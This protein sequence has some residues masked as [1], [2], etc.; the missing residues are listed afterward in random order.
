[1]PGM[2]GALPPL[3]VPFFGGGGHDRA[4]ALRIDAAALAA[5][6]VRPNARLLLLDGLDP[7][8]DAAGRLAWTSL[9]QAEADADLLFLGLREGCPIFAQITSNRSGIDARSRSVWRVLPLLDAQDAGLY[10]AARSLIDWHVRHG[11]CASCGT[12][13]AM[14]KGGWART[15][16]A[17]GAEHFPRVDPVVIMLAEHQGRVL[18][19]RQ[20]GFPPGRYSALAGFL[21]VGE[22]IED[23]VARELHEEAG[24]IV[25][26]VRYV[27]SQPWPFPSSLMIGCVAQAASDVITLD[28][29][30]LEDA[31]W[32][33][34]AGVA[35]ALADDAAAPF[36][37]PP[38]FAIAHHLLVHW[39]A[40]A[41]SPQD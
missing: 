9:A 19:G 36:L 20:P 21:E 3:G 13:T 5:Q 22:T 35:A 24:L 1:M 18:L 16:S 17:C 23:A 26:D 31:I 8:L 14:A 37:A 38:P 39:L 25:G 40:Q 27:A 12:A 11:F 34:H 15:C 7:R 41:A 4:D 6:M 30:E 28:R 10:A 2:A 29:N 32:V 33:D